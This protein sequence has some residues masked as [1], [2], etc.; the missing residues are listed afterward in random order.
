M[1]G[2]LNQWLLDTVFRHGKLHFVSQLDSSASV[3]DVGCGNNSPFQIKSLL[4]NS[5]YTGID[6][7]DYNQTR[8]NPAD[9]Y[10]LTSPENFTKAIERFDAEFDAVISSHNL[11]HCDDRDGTFLAMLRAVRLNG[12]IFVCFPCEA[13]VTMPSR[14]GTLN[15]YDDP[16]HKTKPPDFD[17]L[18]AICAENGF[19]IIFSAKRFKPAA[20]WLLGLVC[21][22]ISR[23]KRKVLRGTWALYGFESVLIARKIREN[24]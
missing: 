23:I 12:K 24:K 3:L 7:A 15:Y 11:E 1:S 5:T 16:T 8:P 18:I 2:R 19:E 4:P 17:R 9:R 22:P 14:P 6:I 13:S 10:I 21:E 20:L